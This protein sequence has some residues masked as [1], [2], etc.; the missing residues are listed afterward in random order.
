MK[1]FIPRVEYPESPPASSYKLRFFQLQ[2][3]AVFHDVL[4]VLFALFVVFAVLRFVG[5]VSVSP[6]AENIPPFSSDS[7]KLF[8]W[9]RET[10][11]LAAEMVLA[12]AAWAIE[13]SASKKQGTT[14]SGQR[15]ADYQDGRKVEASML[16]F[17]VR[18]RLLD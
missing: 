15:T 16:G 17:E 12:C 18:D 9:R 5:Y 7:L 8:V 6:L 13:L 2:R 14:Q 3:V 4:Q 1:R 11:D 10:P